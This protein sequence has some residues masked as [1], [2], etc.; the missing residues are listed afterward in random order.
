MSDNVRTRQEQL[1]DLLQANNFLSVRQLSEEL[2]VSPLTIRRDLDVLQVDGLIERV[3]GGA[4]LRGDRRHGRDKNELA[5]FTRLEKEIDEKTAIAQAA[6]NE[7]WPDQVILLDSSTTG[8]YL[9]QYIPRDLNLTLVTHSAYLPVVLGDRDNLQI[10]STGGMLHPRSMCFLGSD[11]ENSLTSFHAHTAFFGAK[12]VT[13]E[14][15]CTDA[16]LLE[17]Q[18]KA[19]MAQQVERLVVLADHTKLG[20]VGLA[21]FATLGQ[22]D[23]LITDELADAAIVAAIRNQGVQVTL[24]ALKRE[25]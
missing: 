21:A 24:A 17:I 4:K 19:R 2:C 8:L 7:L 12:G 5:Y 18:I 22:V 11:A 25:D 6:I 13:P 10:I 16:H 14:E 1:I 20:N 3:H 15:G 23:L 9:A